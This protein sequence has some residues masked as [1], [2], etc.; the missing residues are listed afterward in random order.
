[1]SFINRLITQCTT[2]QLMGNMGTKYALVG[3]AMATILGVYA[4]STTTMAPTTFFTVA[5][6]DNVPQ[7]V[8]HVTLTVADSDG[9]VKSYQQ[10]DNLVTD[11]GLE[12][13]LDILFD[14]GGCGSLGDF[15]HIRLADN[16]TANAVS[17]T[18]S[19][20]SFTVEVASSLVA[21]T[22]SITGFVVT[23]EELFTV[24]DDSGLIADDTVDRTALFDDVAGG[25]MLAHADLSSTTV[26]AGD[27]ITVTWTITGDN[28]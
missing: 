1:M 2:F 25:N 22:V 28:P 7:L 26:T 9:N 17:D 19:D 3:I 20:T 27:T 23:V 24:G 12:C 11:Q 5:T 10:T 21:D 15:N 13:A 4:I 18:D 14:V 8:G 16:G 6:Y